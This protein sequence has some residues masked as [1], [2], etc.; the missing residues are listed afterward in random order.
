MRSWEVVEPI[1]FLEYQEVFIKE[2]WKKTETKI[3]TPLPTPLI[4]LDLDPYDLGSGLI[5]AAPLAC[6]QCLDNQEKIYVS[7][8]I[9]ILH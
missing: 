9:V 1:L 3:M 6:P 7:H 4:S 2:V 5:S 8:S